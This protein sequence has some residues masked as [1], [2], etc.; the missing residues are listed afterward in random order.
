MV[1]VPIPIAFGPAFEG[2]RIRKSDTHVEFGGGRSVAYELVRSAPPEEVHDREIVVDGPDLHGLPAGS[3]L[4][5]GSSSGSQGRGC[6]TTSNRS[7]SAAST[8]SSITARGRCTW[9][10]GTPPGSRLDGGCGEGFSLADLG[11]MLYASSTRTS[12]TSWTRCRCRS[13]HGLRMCSRA[14]GGAR[15]LRRTGRAGAD[16]DRR[17][18]LRVHSCTLCQSFAP[19]HVCI[20]SPER[21]GLCG[22]I[23]WLDGRRGSRSPRPAPTSR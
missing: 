16:A 5:L 23:N 14:D 18:R 17:C 7:S 21:L 11:L 4:P 22:A 8:G 9:H 3:V 1:K 10:S 12:R 15:R 19:N 13:R 2:E 20:V 6:S